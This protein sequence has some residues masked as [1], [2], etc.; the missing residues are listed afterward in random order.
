MEKEI[1]KSSVKKEDKDLVVFNKSWYCELCG[2]IGLF[3]FWIMRI[4]KIPVDFCIS[5]SKYQAGF[6]K[7]LES[8]QE[9]EKVGGAVKAYDDGI[10][11]VISEPIKIMK[12][13]ECEVEFVSSELK[14]CEQVVFELYKAYKVEDF[15]KMDIIFSEYLKNF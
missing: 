1:I 6:K 15:K 10:Y 2:K 12:Q 4:I 13:K 9:N 3:L 11:D 14:S 8:M 7:A 5:K